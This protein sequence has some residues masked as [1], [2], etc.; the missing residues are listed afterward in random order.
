MGVVGLRPPAP[1]SPL[2]QPASVYFQNNHK[3]SYILVGGGI[4]SRFLRKVELDIWISG[5]SLGYIQCRPEDLGVMI[6]KFSEYGSLR[7]HGVLNQAWK[8]IFQKLEK[9][10][11]GGQTKIWS[12]YR[13]NILYSLKWK[14]PKKAIFFI[15]WLKMTGREGRSPQRGIGV[16]DNYDF[17]RFSGNPY[18][19]NWC[20][21]I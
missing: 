4:F 7:W 12:Y 1:K 3:Y 10:T 21:L 14:C 11:P 17:R 13:L 20:W 18:K 6:F 19:T 2:Q 16:K 5:D 9:Y 15:K 8:C